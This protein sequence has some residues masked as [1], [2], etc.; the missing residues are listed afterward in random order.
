MESASM[1][2]IPAYD[3]GSE[4]GLTEGNIKELAQAVQHWIAYKRLTGF[5]KLLGEGLLMTPVAE[6]FVG[7]GWTVTA[8]TDVHELEKTGKPGYVNID[9]GVGQPPR[10]VLLELKFLTKKSHNYARLHTDVVKLAIP[11]AAHQRLAVVALD[12]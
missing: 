4:R 11:T 1:N 6:Y 12:L 5:E 10:Q 7:H 2:I 3:P 8:E 9:L